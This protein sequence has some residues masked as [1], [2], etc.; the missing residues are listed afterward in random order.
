MFAGGYFADAYFAGDPQ[1]TTGGGPVAG[2]VTLSGSGALVVTG[3]PAVAGAVSLAGS[4]TL[5]VTGVPAVSGAVALSGSGTLAVAGAPAING[6]VT[7][8]GSGSLV[9]TGG[10][11]PGTV[12]LSGSGTLV[13][14]G[15]AAIA[16]TAAFSGSGT[17]AV[18]GVPRVNGTASLAGSGILAVTGVPA[19]A[20]A[21]ALSGSGTLIVAGLLALSGSASFTGS[22]ALTVLGTASSS[23]TVVIIMAAANPTVTY[24]SGYDKPFYAGF[25]TAPAD[26]VPG[27]YPV[28]INGRPYILNT[29]HTQ[30]ELYGKGFREDSLPLLRD[31]T[32]QLNLPGEQ[33]LSPAQYW[34]RSQDD[35]RG[36]A[37]Q[38]I[39]DRT[40]SDVTRFNTSKGVNP[41]TRY[42]MTLL[43]DTTR[44][45]TTS[46]TGLVGTTANGSFYVADGTTVRGTA[47]LLAFTAVTGTPASQALSM[48]SDGALVYG[49]FNTSGIYTIN[50]AT[51]TSYVT[52][53]V[54]LVGY[55]KGRLLAAQG[56]ALYNPVA[57]GALPTAFYTNATTGWAWTAFAEGDSFIY[58]SGGAGD[59]SRIYRI[60]IQPDGTAL[61]VPVQ[62][63]T[64]P[65]GEIVRSMLGYLGFIVVGTDKGVRFAT[66]DSSTGDLTL[67]ALI[68]TPG[69][70]YCLD[71]AD[72][73]V[74]FGW[75]NYDAVSSGI[76]RFDLQRINDGNA[77]AFA[78]DLMATGQ[79][80]VRAM[81][82]LTG[83]HIFAVDGLGAFAEQTTPVASGAFTTGQISYGI[84]D[85][86]VPIAVDLKHA[87]L[88]VGTSVS[89]AMASDRG[90]AA[91]I[92]AS[93]AVG[94]VSPPAA[95]TTGSKRAEE[96]E[97]TFTL[98]SGVSGTSPLLVRYT[99]L[100]YPAPTG[101]SMYI[102]PIILAAAVDNLRNVEYR[103]DVKAEYEFLRAL[104]T[105]REV[106]TCQVGS[107]TFQGTLEEFHWIP[108]RVTADQT[109]WDG[110]F[111]AEIRRI[112]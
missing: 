105:S 27:R 34:R 58:A 26:L 13:V 67:G 22:G 31:Q 92:G 93:S 23:G 32:D 41:W 35:W 14:T 88:V 21:V 6:T 103:M 85:P 30:I 47:N 111:L 104:N 71:A 98:V 62:A 61:T 106:I 24:D 101:A 95:I 81:G 29:D 90:A 89:V 54:A 82:Q 70:V 80:V 108:D 28:A 20:G 84:S 59:T 18:A 74:W 37:G 9:V 83:R 78:T 40:T 46:N 60:T 43:N 72:H 102:L 51:A 75:S 109:F 19:I 1:A 3:V 8:S 69:P 7:L 94:S 99:L 36:G 44:I 66:A 52:G 107:S 68:Q 17:L 4:G 63:A 56:G 42:Q 5:A 33:S 110:T 91:T 79:G 96:V 100:S 11:I 87:P 77:P 50:G 97:L 49:A 15:A 64:L 55:A 12:T 10:A 86:K 53:T 112:S 38:S 48:C 2:T 16:G 76:G 65:K 45:L 57:A 73:F 39:L 25:S